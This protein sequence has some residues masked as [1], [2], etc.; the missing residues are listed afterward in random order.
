MLAS[1]CQNLERLALCGSDSVGDP[2]ISCIAAKCVALKTR[3]IKGCPVSD[4]GMEALANGCANGED[5]Y[6][7]Q[8]SRI[9]RVAKDEIRDWSFLDLKVVD[10]CGWRKG[11]HKSG[12]RDGCQRGTLC[13]SSL[14]FSLQ[15]KLRFGFAMVE[16][17][18]SVHQ[19]K[20]T[21]VV[22]FVEGEGHDRL[23]SVKGLPL[24]V[25]IG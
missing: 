20:I 3:C 22:A 10:S 24:R 18:Q 16:V 17:V 6:D 13:V 1:N 8:C 7:L 5:E 19:W 11:M 25:G 9:G 21:V 14:D 2:E 23:R 12:S 4:E 15:G